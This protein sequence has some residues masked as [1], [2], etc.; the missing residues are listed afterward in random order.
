MLKQVLPRDRIYTKKE[1]YQ[2]ISEGKMKVIDWA[3]RWRWPDLRSW[4]LPWAVGW[5][6]CFQQPDLGFSTRWLDSKNSERE[7]TSPREQ[8]LSCLLRSQRQK[9]NH[10]VKAKMS[11]GERAQNQGTGRWFIRDCRGRRPWQGCWDG[12]Q[13]CDSWRRS[14]SC[15][16][17]ELRYPEEVA[18]SEESTPRNPRRHEAWDRIS[19]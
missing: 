17:R 13:T 19:V 8:V 1:K 15:Q 9:V 12:V 16:E 4:P 5:A 7:R 18:G 3:G 11:V 2:R 6:A 14:G 10:T